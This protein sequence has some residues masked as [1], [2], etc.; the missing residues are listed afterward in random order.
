VVRAYGLHFLML[1]SVISVKMR[2]FVR[3]NAHYTKLSY[4]AYFGLFP[5][6][7]LFCHRFWQISDSSLECCMKLYANFMHY[8]L[9][10]CNLLTIFVVNCKLYEKRRKCNICNQLRKASRPNKAGD[11]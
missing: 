2:V 7:A 11:Y 4:C 9:S 8:R 5:N 6:L 1:M 3:F 10:I